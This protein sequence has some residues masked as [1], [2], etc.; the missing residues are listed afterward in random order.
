MPLA[1]HKRV[2]REIIAT[3]PKGREFCARSKTSAT[4]YRCV[5]DFQ[6]RKMS[7]FIVILFYVENARASGLPASHA[8]AAVASDL[9][10]KRRGLREQ[11]VFS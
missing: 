11:R 1:P 2:H 4:V 8:L 5:V 7:R 10:N 9:Y 6:A 3:R